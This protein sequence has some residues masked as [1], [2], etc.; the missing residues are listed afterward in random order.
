MVGSARRA[1]SLRARQQRSIAWWA[2]I[3]LVHLA[4]VFALQQTLR[5]SQQRPAAPPAVTWLRLPPPPSETPRQPPP[6]R[7]ATPAQPS[8]AVRP[9][10]SPVPPAVPPPE[11]AAITL[12]PPTD[13][14]PPG[15]LLDSAATREAVREIARRPLLGERAAAATGTAL[16]ASRD[17][18][19][20]RQTERAAKG[21]CMKGEFAGGGMGLLSLPALAWAAVSGE[22][23]K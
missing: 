4:L 10:P 1:P 21:D 18:V 23:A 7:A 2:A 16:P 12:P 20:A 8:R 5:R 14:P 17:E 19:L 6:P 11:P 15:P 22:C 3:V 9:P 13:V